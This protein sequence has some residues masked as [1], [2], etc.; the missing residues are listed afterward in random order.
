MYHSS[1]AR[2][3]LI[4]RCGTADAPVAVL[5]PG[6]KEWSLAQAVDPERVPA[7]IAMIMDGNG[8]GPQARTAARGGTPGGHGGAEDR[9]RSRFTEPA[10]EVTERGHQSI[11]ALA[12]AT[13][14]L[15][16]LLAHPPRL[17]SE[18][19]YSRI[20]LREPKRQ[21]AQSARNVIN[22]HLSVA[23]ELAELLTILPALF[24]KTSDDTLEAV[25]AFLRR[26]CRQGAFYILFA[27]P[28]G[29]VR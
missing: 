12:Q 29:V 19:I 10:D 21:I 5:K 6:A 11:D 18:A 14:R 28:A 27:G 15:P 13:V 20:C 2:V 24:R 17:L 23:P 4:R 3:R 16:E 7:H 22:L 25:E 1:A 26:H 8:R 9:L